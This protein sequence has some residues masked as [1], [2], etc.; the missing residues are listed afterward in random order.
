VPLVSLPP[1]LLREILVPPSEVCFASL[2]ARTRALHAACLV[3]TQ[4]SGLATER[5]YEHV[6]LA[7]VDRAEFF[8]RTLESEAWTTGSLARR[9]GQAARPVG[10]V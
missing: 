1:E 4:L 3:C 9:R 6:L 8:L 5:L 10:Q 7:G 2:P